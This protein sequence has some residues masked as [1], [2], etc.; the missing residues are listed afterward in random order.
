M[1]TNKKKSNM[2]SF[3]K[4]GDIANAI[5][6]TL[7]IAYAACVVLW[8]DR[9]RDG[10]RRS[11]F[12]E[13]WKQ[14]G[15]CI[16]HKNIPF[17]S[18]FDTCMY[19]DTFFSICLGILY[20]CWKD[21]P[22]MQTSSDLV[23]FVI[24][25]TLAH[26]FAH[27]YEAFMWRQQQQQQQTNL[28]EGAT[29]I[30]TEEP[31]PTLLGNII[32]CIVF[33]FPLLK[34]SLIHVHSKFVA[35]MSICVTFGMTY[36]EERYVFTYIQSVLLIASHTNQLMLPLEEKDKSSYEYMVLPLMSALPIVL[37][38]WVEAIYCTAFYQS[39]GGHVLYDACIIVSFLLYYISC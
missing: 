22:G 12:D 36:M 11:F 10:K 32:F 21:H 4:A 39:L 35:I 3:R 24:I 13:Q 1:R 6:L 28:L 37:T 9:E 15:F 16:Q 7:A 25:G 30:T 19:V 18:S 14:E 33:W 2:I 5:V 29:T 26:G 34:A 38:G 31:E 17:W 8:I 23:P 27:E 20:R